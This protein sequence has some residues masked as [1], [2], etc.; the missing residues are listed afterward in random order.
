MC[1]IRICDRVCDR[2]PGSVG[3]YGVAVGQGAVSRVLSDVIRWSHRGVSGPDRKDSTLVPSKSFTIYSD[4]VLDAA[5]ALL[6]VTTVLPRVATL[7]S[8]STVVTL[9]RVLLLDNTHLKP[10]WDTRS[11]QLHRRRR[12]VTAALVPAWPPF[13]V[14]SCVKR[15]ANAVWNV[16]NAAKCAKASRPV[17]D[18]DDTIIPTHRVRDSR[19]G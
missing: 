6:L 7:P 4:S 17:N 8:S 3:G 2:Y 5:T 11:N 19:L 15:A 12:K 18:L 1:L 10:P 13:A 9:L 16:S 14:V